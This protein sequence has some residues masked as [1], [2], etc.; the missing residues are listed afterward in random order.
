MKLRDKLYKGTIREKDSQNNSNINKEIP[1]LQKISTQNRRSVK[2]QRNPLQE[3]THYKKYF[4]ENE[5]KCKALS[6]GI[7]EIIYW[8]KKNDIFS[9]L[10]LLINGK[11]ITEKFSITENYNNSFA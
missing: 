6:D 11:T 3:K 10:S 8:K 4:E 5:K 1:N 7:H 9:P 2:S